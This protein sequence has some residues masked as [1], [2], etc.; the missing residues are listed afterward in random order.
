M[1]YNPVDNSQPTCS[2]DQY[3]MSPDSDEGTGASCKDEPIPTKTGEIC[4]TI[5]EDAF[6]TNIGTLPYS[7]NECDTSHTGCTVYTAEN[8]N[9]DNRYC[10]QADST[11][12]IK[13]LAGCD[14]CTGKNAEYATAEWKADRK[15]DRYP[16]MIISGHC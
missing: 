7:N 5:N 3:C 12:T 6:G 14:D 13:V 8:C 10:K 11:G 1:C 15:D 4:K 16:N 2:V 9:I